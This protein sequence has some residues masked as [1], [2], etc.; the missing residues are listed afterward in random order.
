MRYRKHRLCAYANVPEGNN[1]RVSV[2]AMAHKERA[3]LGAA[4][5]IVLGLGA[6]HAPVVP[7]KQP[8]PSL[9]LHTRPLA[10]TYGVYFGFWH[11]HF[12]LPIEHIHRF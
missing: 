6:R 5:E 1:E 8:P 10:V 2:L 4:L 3:V 7:L 11:L 9:V 12:H